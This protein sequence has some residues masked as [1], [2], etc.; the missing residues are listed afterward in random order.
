MSLKSCISVVLFFALAARVGAQDVHPEVQ[1]LITDLSVWIDQQLKLG[2]T[3]DTAVLNKKSAYIKHVQDSIA[4][5]SATGTASAPTD[6]I[7][8]V[9]TK[10]IMAGASLKVPE[11][12]KWRILGV[13]VKNDNDPYR[14][15]VTSWNYKAEYFSGESIRAPGM[16]S[17]EALLVEDS[18]EATY[19]FDISETPE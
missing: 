2:G 19:D 6:K 3:M 7:G 4:M 11:G 9:F 5:V 15:K 10:S 8:K 16:V 13:Y 1:A 12:K 17:E 18:Q 14:I